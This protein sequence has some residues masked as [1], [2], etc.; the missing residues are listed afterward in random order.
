MKEWFKY[1]YGYV[2]IDDDNIY[3]TN[4]GNWSEVG[5]LKEKSGVKSN[6]LRK[7]R[8]QVF[9]IVVGVLAAFLLFKNVLSGEV[10]ILLIVGL[11]I[12][13]FLVY[14]YLKTEIGSNYKLP[15]CKVSKIEIED[16]EVTNVFNNSK[17]GVNKEVLVNVEEKGLRILNDLKVD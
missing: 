12:S 4:T 7:I 6:K 2:N 5:L 11:P 3:F 17:S 16:N 14:K 13:V 8:I 1:E 15:I 10:S 9:L